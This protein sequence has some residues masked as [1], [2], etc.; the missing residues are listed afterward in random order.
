MRRNAATILSVSVLFG[1]ALGLYEYAFP[2]FLRGEGIDQKH[3]GA[4]YSASLVAM[5]LLRIYAGNHSEA[6]GRKRFY[7]G[8]L[9]ACGLATAIGPVYAGIG[10]LL[11]RG[12]AQL[13]FKTVREGAV[14]VREAM[15]PV[16]IFENLKARFTDVV[17][18]SRS[19]DFLGQS[20]GK[21]A[22]GALVALAVIAG[23]RAEGVTLVAAGALLLCGAVIFH[24]GFREAGFRPGAKQKL[25]LAE[26]L[27][28]GLPRELVLIAV[29]GFVFNFGLFT[30][31]TF[32]LSTWF[33]DKFAA[34]QAQNGVILALHRLSL[35]LPL[36][37][38]G[39]VLLARPKWNLKP[40]FI[41]TI[42]GEG[43]L[44]A[45]SAVVP[46]PYFLAAVVIWLFHDIVGA[47]IW[48]SIQEYYIQR[49]AREGSRGLDVSRVQAFA[50]MGRVFGPLATSALIALF[51]RT[52]ASGAI[53]SDM[54]WLVSGLLVIASVVPL[55]LLPGV[56]IGDEETLEIA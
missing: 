33:V 55:V 30:S 3:M 15:H 12:M 9:A 2:W 14:A 10:G 50:S 26:L 52:S 11:T 25:T 24:C 32:V 38:S 36:F 18:K 13:S 41:G 46:R 49:F 5:Y 51:P 6:L 40:I 27:P 21:L 28:F 31:H 44:I 34:S 37:F 22:G 16:L 53:Y 19:V 17:A 42:V 7:T 45:A 29:A 35:G 56:R 39:R 54:P 47:G 23:V 1:I 20:A 48:M 43:L 4:I 8:A